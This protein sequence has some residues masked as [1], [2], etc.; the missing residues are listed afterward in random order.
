MNLVDDVHVPFFIAAVTDGRRKR[1]DKENVFTGVEHA[2]FKR[3]SARFRSLF[4]NIHN[5]IV[6]E[7]SSK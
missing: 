2:V 6:V 7:T 1:T 4:S 5:K 3:K